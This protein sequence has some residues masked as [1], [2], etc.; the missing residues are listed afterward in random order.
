MTSPHQTETT[1]IHTQTP[2]ATPHT[3]NTTSGTASAAIVIETPHSNRK[4][5][6]IDD[7]YTHKNSRRKHTHNSDSTPTPRVQKQK[8]LD[9]FFLRRVRNRVDKPDS[10]PRP[11]THT[12]LTHPSTHCT[13]QRNSSSPPPPKRG[14]LGEG[15]RQ[16][17]D[18]Q[19]RTTSTIQHQKR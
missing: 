5:Q 16:P 10:A 18:T 2:G 1:Q 15:Y 7:L 19:H 14:G 6:R 11:T 17:H 3:H 4:Q 13:L 9:S 8:R 12:Q